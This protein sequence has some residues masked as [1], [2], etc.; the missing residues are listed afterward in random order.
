MWQHIYQLGKNPGYKDLLNRG[1]RICRSQ[2]DGFL[3]FGPAYAK[4]ASAP[5]DA[6]L[7]HAE[8]RK[9]NFLS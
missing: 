6:G 5:P 8:K 7:T 1:G 4:S 9:Q 3:D 2:N